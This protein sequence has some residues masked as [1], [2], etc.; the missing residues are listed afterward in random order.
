MHLA[1][2][3]WRRAEQRARDDHKAIGSN[4]ST[5]W[6]ILFIARP[7]NHAPAAPSMLPMSAGD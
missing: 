4:V 3:S 7:M 2:W 5:P 1:G 6:I